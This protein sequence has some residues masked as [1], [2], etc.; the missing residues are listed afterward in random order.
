MILTFCHFLGATAVV[1]GMLVASLIFWTFRTNPAQQLN[2]LV[3][4]IYSVLVYI[5]ISPC[6]YAKRMKNSIGW[7]G[8]VYLSAPPR[9]PGIPR[10]FSV[11]TFWEY[12]WALLGLNFEFDF[13][14]F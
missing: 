10:I 7:P 4:V 9:I 5:T 14:S 3:A 8:D 11:R 6:R 13:I 1:P 2:L 12:D